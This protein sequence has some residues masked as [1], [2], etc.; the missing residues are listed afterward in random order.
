MTPE[1][2]VKNQIRK[3]L[4]KRGAYYHMTVT[5][6]YGKSGAPDFLVCYRGRA[7]AV[8]A[9]AGKGTTTALQDQQLEKIEKAGGIA[10]VVSDDGVSIKS[11]E[12]MLD[13]I[14]K[15]VGEDDLEAA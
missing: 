5:G 14:D 12:M 3:L 11:L 6:G 9:K 15:M 10:M 2:K 8:E 1:V 4:D 7:I 13:F